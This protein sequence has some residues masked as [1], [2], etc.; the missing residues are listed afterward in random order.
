MPGDLG[1]DHRVGLGHALQPG[2]QIGRLADNGVVVRAASRDGVADNHQAGRDADPHS[3][4]HI[5]ELFQTSIQLGNSAHQFEP[6]TYG[7]FSIVLVRYRK[8]EIDE[9]AIAHMS[10]DVAIIEP[11]RLGTGSLIGGD[12]VTKILGIK[13][14]RQTDRIHKITEHERQLSSLGLVG[15]RG[16][17]RRGSAADLYFP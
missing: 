1:H 5:S 13:P 4:I 15:Q 6:G 7:P 16:S 12:Q 17:N 3:H 2:G 10:G 9:N 11:D 8:P 14:D